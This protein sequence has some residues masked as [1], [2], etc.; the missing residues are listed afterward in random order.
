MSGGDVTDE[1]LFTDD[2]LTPQWRYFAH[3]GSSAQLTGS[4]FY[5]SYEGTRYV[6]T[7]TMH[8]HAKKGELNHSNNPTFV[9]YGQSKT[10]VSGAEIWNEPEANSVKNIVKSPY[11]NVT[12]SFQRETY[13]SKIGV[14]DEDGD[15]IA[16]ANLATPVK[17]TTKQDY[18]FKL[19]LDL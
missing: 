19:K 10:N 18:T 14:Y 9:T 17:K 12:E 7:L 1:Y 15:L 13:I 4:A 6:P 3:T 2:A 8:A 5:I 16:V 11:D